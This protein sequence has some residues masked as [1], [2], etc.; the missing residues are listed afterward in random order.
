V[1]RRIAV[2]LFVSTLV[3][4]ATQAQE[5]SVRRLAFLFPSS[6]PKPDERS[7]H[8]AAFLERLRELGWTEN[9]N[10][11]VETRFAD[12]DFSR[13]PALADE[14]VRTKPDV[15]VAETNFTV[16]AAQKATS[17][18]PIVMLSVTNPVGM[19]FVTDLR[20]PGGNLTGVTFD[21][22]PAIWGKRLEL[23]K[24]VVPRLTR[25]TALLNPALLNPAF[26]GRVEHW[27]ALEDGAR[28]LGLAL[29][30][31]EYT[32]V[33]DFERVLR[34]TL[35]RRPQAIYLLG[36]PATYPHRFLIAELTAKHRVPA[37]YNLLFYA[38]VGGLMAYGADLNDV[39]RRAAEYV[40]RILRGAKPSELP[41]EQPTKFY[42]VIN[43][44]AAKA[45]GLTIPP[46]LLLRADRVI[47]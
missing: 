21:V 11:V 19:G 7:S 45:I 47:E 34:S 46:S 43:Q 16:A 15:I 37:V 9:R 17:T 23:L 38:E 39:W 31:V 26:P 42:L 6:A 13:L 32:G 36:D 25:V 44:R 41:V 12:G 33:N 35:K 20:R 2:F 40:D 24:A 18:I 14:L 1:I 8:W 28:T 29:E 3:A 22:D 5:A 27:R 30:R 4:G 10:I